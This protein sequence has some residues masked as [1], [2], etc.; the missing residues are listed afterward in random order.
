MSL[1]AT[2][3]QLE[4]FLNLRAATLFTFKAWAEGG[5]HSNI[6]NKSPEEKEVLLKNVSWFDPGRWLWKQTCVNPG[7]RPGVCQPW[8]LCRGLGDNAA[9][10]TD[11][12]LLVRLLPWAQPN[13]AWQLLSGRIV[14]RW[15]PFQ[16]AGL[17]MKSLLSSVTQLLEYL[18]RG[19]E[20]QIHSDWLKYLCLSGRTLR[21]KHAD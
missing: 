20:H 2:G 16:H 15:E 12:G 19:S 14:W 10:C 17:K 7:A 18:S 6:N 1:C 5:N 9:P 21:W 8:W 11:A 13:K 3:L 4:N